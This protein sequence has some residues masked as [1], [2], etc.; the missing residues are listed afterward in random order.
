M[1]K[2]INCKLKRNVNYSLSYLSN[3]GQSRTI[4]I[5]TVFLSQGLINDG[6]TLCNFI[7]KHC[8]DSEYRSEL[9]GYYLVLFHNHILV[10]AKQAQSEILIQ[11]VFFSM[12]AMTLSPNISTSS[13]ITKVKL[14]PNLF[15]N[16][17]INNAQR[18]IFCLEYLS[19]LK[20]IKDI[21]KEHML[22]FYQALLNVAYVTIFNLYGC[23]YTIPEFINETFEAIIKTMSNLC[24]SKEYLYCINILSTLF[25]AI[26]KDS[27]KYSNQDA[28]DLSECNKNLRGFIRKY[29]LIPPL[30]ST[31]HHISK[32]LRTV[33][34]YYSN[35]TEIWIMNMPVQLQIQILR[36]IEV[37]ESVLV[38][39]T[40]EIE[41]FC[42]DCKFKTDIFLAAT[43][44]SFSGEF[45]LKQ[46]RLNL[47]IIDEIHQITLKLYK[48]CCQY[49]HEIWKK[50]C[51]KIINVWRGVG[52]TIYNIGVVLYKN[53]HYEIAK[54]YM[55]L[56]ISNVIMIEGVENTD[57]C[58]QNSLG[59]S[60]HLLASC[61]QYLNNKLPALQYLALAVL[62]SEDFKL[63]A[64]H[65]WVAIKVQVSEDQSELRYYTIHRVL[66][67]NSQA[68]K[69]IYPGYT[70]NPK[71]IESALL[72]ELHYYV[73]TWNSREAIYNCCL[74]ICNVSESV[75]NKTKALTWSWE[76]ITQWQNW[77]D[78]DII[79][80]VETLIKSIAKSNEKQ[81]MICLSVLSFILYQ[82]KFHH[83]IV[84]N[85]EDMNSAQIPLKNVPLQPFEDPV[86]PN[87][88]CDI[89]PAFNNLK[90]DNA[91]KLYQILD[92]C[93]E[94]WELLLDTKESNKFDFTP[95]AD[96]DVGNFIKRAAFECR[97]QHLQVKMLKLWFL[98]LKFARLTDDTSN[99]ISSIGFLLEYSD[100]KSKKIIELQK[101]AQQYLKGVEVQ[102]GLYW[103]LTAT[104]YI[105]L[106]TAY[107]NSN[108]VDKAYEV[109][110][111]LQ[112]M[113]LEKQ[114]ESQLIEIRMLHLQTRF[115]MMPCIQNIMDHEE[116]FLTT[117]QKAYFL[118]ADYY[119][120]SKYTC[121]TPISQK[122]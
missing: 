90:I 10:N 13:F 36:T 8:L 93:I 118:I 80:H 117:A 102:D 61:Y 119:K 4:N 98:S 48:K 94:I 2:T 87:D 107:L 26:V 70:Y 100:C 105:N 97:L 122:I 85:L 81:D 67:M 29:G 57:I 6:M 60:L 88:K 66:T 71:K 56:F 27:K 62:L 19:I 58:F 18:N 51:E 115:L 14:Y 3:Y 9:Y 113:P 103:N 37:L 30:I 32:V 21:K 53:K 39:N 83:V 5:N 38:E 79:S 120:L 68:I 77:K 86:N 54:S 114:I 43:I 47:P 15:K 41:K 20:T 34:E 44:T 112:N 49:I 121:G 75:V 101:E 28:A 23:D 25:N 31:C 78:D 52:S 73:N 50:D 89:V 84:N 65:T 59:S 35:N 74:D 24:Q 72:S 106:C 69:E 99:I 55:K 96:F 95:F 63:K 108:N 110:W 17:N 64:L 12:K 116:N 109:F 92:K 104:F 11:S 7:K 46:A 91:L 40:F 42:T 16:T 22:E 76:K 33:F 82:F 111:T 45:V 1:Q